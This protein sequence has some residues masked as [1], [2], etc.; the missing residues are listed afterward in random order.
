MFLSCGTRDP[1]DRKDNAAQTTGSSVLFETCLWMSMEEYM[2]GLSPY[3]VVSRSPPFALLQIANMLEVFGLVEYLC[4]LGAGAGI[5]S[6]C[7][8]S[9]GRSGNT[10]LGG[11]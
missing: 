7:P 4:D 2:K 8:R 9:F 11:F 5:C 1:H 3:E 6:I 10:P